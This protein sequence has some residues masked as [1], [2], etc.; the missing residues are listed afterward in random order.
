[1]F[2]TARL[3]LTAWYTL[4]L[5]LI[6]AVLSVAL[7]LLL[8]SA[9][10]SE[11]QSVHGQVGHT[12]SQA[13][14]H[15]EVLLAYQIIA[16]DLG[17]LILAALGAYFL[18]GRTLQPIR[19]VMERQRRFAAAASHELRTPLTGLRGTLEVALL[20][21]RS[22]EEYQEVIR[23]SVE[24]TERMG[25]LVKDLTMLAQAERAVPLTLAPLDLVS[26]A[27]EAVRDVQPLAV[28]KNQVVRLDL[29]QSL[30]VQADPLKFRQALTNL[31]ENAVTYTEDGGSIA[32][33][34]K[35]ERGQAVLEIR[36]TGVGIS[37]EHLT[38][39]FEPFYQIDGARGV[40]DHVGLGLALTAWIV[41]AHHGRIEVE[42]HE[43]VGSTFR[44][45]L[46]LA[47]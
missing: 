19:E 42:S 20:S 23:E 41:R 7:Y 27:G 37:Q 13:F 1:M 39:L 12:I 11:L 44:L 40:A 17:V 34:G 31:L 3:R 15:D 47:D 10:R 25:R 45:S 5:A 32:L 35:R 28:R 26:I 21:R 33:L 36:D 9:Q 4:I 29:P 16:A 8:L 18:A 2:D 24:E 14:A 30:P 43:G 38:H 6:L 46:P 22:P